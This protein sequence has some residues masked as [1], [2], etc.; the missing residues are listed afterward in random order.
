VT[1]SN[2]ALASSGP[3]SIAR[4]ATS[5]S[6]KKETDPA[7]S[8]SALPARRSS[9]VGR[10]A[11]VWSESEYDVLRNN[12]TMTSRQLMELLPG[13]SEK[14][15]SN[16]RE[17]KNLRKAWLIGELETL[18]NN[19]HVPSWKL[20]EMLPGRTVS[21]IQSHR[22]KIGFP[23]IRG[24]PKQPKPPTQAKPVKR[25]LIRAAGC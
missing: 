24:K 9:G 25:K 12:R 15:I 2:T 14:A 16:A 23:L 18:E 19:R 11:N 3:T 20:S 4:T 21:T 8:S 1:I 5:T 22:K 13:R 10:F 17:R 7:R 6:T